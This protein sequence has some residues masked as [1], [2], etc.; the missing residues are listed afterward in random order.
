MLPARVQR[1]HGKVCAQLAPQYLFPTRL[2][3]SPEFRVGDEEVLREA[4]RLAAQISKPLQNTDFS[5]SYRKQATREFALR[6][7]REVAG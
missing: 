6:A 3:R 1:I 2:K 5:Q 7:L 4:A